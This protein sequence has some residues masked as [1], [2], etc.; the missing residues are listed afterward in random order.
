MSRPF[1][2]ELDQALTAA[3]RAPSPH[4]TQPWRFEVDGD[5]VEL[6][7][8][9]D[10]VLT[11]ADP[12]AREA[13]LSCG[14]ALF[15][16]RLSL[17]VNGKEPRVRLLPEPG[18]PD[19][20][21]EIRIDGVRRSTPAERELAE[22][23][24]HRHTNRRPFLDQQVP[25]GL[26]AALNTAALTE[27]GQL[28]HLEPSA[29]YDTVAVLAR[30]AEFLQATDES[31][32]AES[33]RWTRRSAGS[34]DGVPLTAAAPPARHAGAVPQ[35]GSHANAELPARSYEQQPLLVAVLSGGQGALADLRGGLVMQS[36]L[37]TATSLG[38]ATS[39]VSQPFETTETRAALEALF[40]DSGRVHTLL[41]VGYGY[42]TPPTARRPVTEVVHRG[43][44][45]TG[46]PST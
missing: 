28:E 30:R 20:L 14:A 23:V 5:R 29:R 19:L 40:R 13:R 38:L 1:A 6:W 21:A 2:T 44:A 3:T 16:L 32:Q 22:A 45:Q 8:D 17:R 37:L 43:A 9:H 15:N 27:G 36:V 46:G 18:S 26:Q 25:R 31:F 42:A 10:R 7:L 12:D 4:N 33:A 24:F 34:A 41:R 11:V 39:F 35:R